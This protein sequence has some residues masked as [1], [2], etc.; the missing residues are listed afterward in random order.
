MEDGFDSQRIPKDLLIEILSYA[1]ENTYNIAL[2][3][4]AWSQLVKQER[5]R[6]RYWIRLVHFKLNKLIGG[7]IDKK[8]LAL[9]DVFCNAPYDLHLGQIEPLSLRHRVGWMFSKGGVVCHFAEMHS[10]I[11]YQYFLFYDKITG[12]GMRWIWE[13]K[14]DVEFAVEFGTY[15]IVHSPKYPQTFG[16]KYIRW[17]PLHPTLHKRLQLEGHRNIYEIWDANRNQMWR[18]P[19]YSVQDTVTLE[20]YMVPLFGPLESHDTPG[21][22]YY[23]NDHTRGNLE[24]H[25]K[26]F[27]AKRVKIISPDQINE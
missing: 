3:C 6:R 18:G 20:K 8:R 21:V 1:A 24:N 9:I 2:V 23:L 15:D 25:R 26:F 13:D 17:F 4:R 12:D 10:Y 22:W 16:G 11:D 27:G 14:C 19:A 5:H 7:H